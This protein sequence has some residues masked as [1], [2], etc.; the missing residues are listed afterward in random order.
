MNAESIR[1]ARAPLVLVA[2]A[3]SGFAGAAQADRAEQLATTVCAA[4][5]GADGNSAVPAFPRLA[6][7]QAEYTVKQLTDYRG[8]R[9]KSEV[10]APLVADLSK[11][12]IAA[13]GAWYEGRKPAPGQTQDAA[14]A[15]LGKRV[16]S[17]GDEGAGQSPCGACHED[18][19]R[20]TAGFP[21]LAGQHAAYT[22]QQMQDFKRGTRSNDKGR[23][24]RV[25]AERMSDADIAA[26][27]EYLAGL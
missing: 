2:L 19:A 21:R 18:D 8:G 7:L 16:W 14:L 10:M 6:G 15:A 4:C 26:V 27:A 17:G 9:R 23:M 5:H 3:L 11:A 20:G 25:L 12:D 1:A 22:A 13:L 24:M